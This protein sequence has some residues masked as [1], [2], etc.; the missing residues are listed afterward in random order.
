MTQQ[1]TRQPPMQASDESTRKQLQLAR[2]QGE[3]LQRA[4]QEMTQQEAHGQTQ[5][6]G[7]YVVGYAVEKAEG[8]YHRRD[9][10]LVWQE[11]QDENVHVEIVV[12]DGSDQRFIPNLTVHAT[13]IDA[14]GHKIGTHEQPFLWHPWLYHY[15]R[16]WR[17]PEDGEYTLR[18]HIDAPA[19]PR[20]DKINGQRYADPVDVEF[21]GVKIKTGQKRG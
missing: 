4:V 10:R 12:A 5:R 20:H 15:G 1:Q 18:V 8:L 6:A 3:A 11:P 9:G 21:T 2:A 19:F 13:L 17:V 14:Q 7:D 16:N